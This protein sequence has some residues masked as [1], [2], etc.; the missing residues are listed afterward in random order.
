MRGSLDGERRSSAVRQ[1]SKRDLCG[2]LGDKNA[3]VEVREEKVM[4]KRGGDYVLLG[5]KFP[6]LDAEEPSAKLKELL[7]LVRSF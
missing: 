5:S 3:S 6:R 7:A 1:P 2:G 4:L